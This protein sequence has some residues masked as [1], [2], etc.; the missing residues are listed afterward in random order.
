MAEGIGTGLLLFV[1]VG[2]GIAASTLSADPGMQLLAHAVAVG[3]GL[4][5]LIVLFQPVSGSHF[6][7]AVT[8]AFWRDGTL[9]AT[10]GGGYVI[11]QVVGAVAGVALANLSF[12]EQLM[13]ISD[14]SRSGSG[15]LVAEGVGTFI[16]VLLILALVRTGRAGL[17][18]VAVGAWI[19][20]IIFATSSTGFANP[21][22]TVA[23]MFT[24]TYTGISPSSVFPFLIVQL[25]AGILAAEAARLLFPVTRQTPINA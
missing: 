9:G 4:G 8:L 12:G 10:E 11:S 24:D 5:V 25:L 13:A 19:G 7:P 21:A 3:L 1:I 18:P 2:S 22:V 23:R 16:L 14:T 20:A 17:V 6:N 15:L